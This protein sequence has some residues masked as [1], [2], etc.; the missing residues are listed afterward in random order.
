MHFILI[1]ILVGVFGWFII[2]GMVHLLFY[3]IRPLVFGPIKW[4]SLANKW[5]N[6]LDLTELMPQLSQNDSFESLKPVIHE[7]LD[8]FFRKKLS[9]KLPMISMFI[10]DKTIEDLKGVFMEELAIIFPILLNQFSNNLNQQ[11]PMQWQEHFS[12]I[13]YLKIRKTTKPISW[14]AFGLGCIWGLAI[15]FIIA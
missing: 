13:A 2:W 6:Q 12:Q 4:E 7:K 1:P 5:V 10:G 3:P 8:D 15:A 11:F 14:I 9:E